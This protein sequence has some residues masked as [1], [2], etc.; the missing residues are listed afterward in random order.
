M[1]Y[2]LRSTAMSVTLDNLN[3]ALNKQ[4]ED[5]LAEFSKQR[6]ELLD[7]F[8]RQKQDLLKEFDIKSQRWNDIVQKAVDEASVAKKMADQNGDEILR[9]KS[10]IETL[11][12]VN[13]FQSKQMNDLSERLESR[14]NRQLRNTLVFK[15]IPET[16]K[17]TS[18]NDTRV[19]LAETVAKCIPSLD[20]Q[21]AHGLFERVHRGRANEH[22]KGRRN[23]FAKLY[24]WDD[25]E[26][27]KTDFRS[28]NIRN[29]NT[30]IY[31]E[32]KFGPMTTYRR[33]QAMTVRRDL[34]ND[35]K[36]YS[37]FVAF[38][39]KL[40]V[41]YSADKKE[42]YVLYEDF[43]ELEVIRAENRNVDSNDISSG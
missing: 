43:S 24:R 22:N 21:T 2:N 42:K 34:K 17:E 3:E 16:S 32:Q 27:L 7:S 4:K 40:L 31:C 28:L 18:W 14:T 23:I 12:K 19:V 38:P 13:D 29:P 30:K 9:L 35:Q 39:A 10:T 15:G 1:A 37:G 6:T 8:E 20:Q 25:A 5:L 36:I 26:Q 33:N 11:V 41:K